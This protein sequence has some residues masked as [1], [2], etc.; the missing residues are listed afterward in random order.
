[1]ET[2]ADTG[3]EDSKASIPIKAADTDTDR[4]VFV[5]VMIAVAMFFVFQGMILAAFQMPVIREDVPF[6][7]PL[8]FAGITQG[9]Y[10]VPTLLLFVNRK[11]PKMAK[12]FGIMTGVVFLG[13]I[14]ALA[15]K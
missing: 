1:M 6:F 15:T 10:A 3:Q 5:G 8:R 9:V 11:C 2:D 4:T 12:G 7:A 14:V 13:G